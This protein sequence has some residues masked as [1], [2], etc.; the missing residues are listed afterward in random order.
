MPGYLLCSDEVGIGWTHN[1]TD[2][3]TPPPPEPAPITDDQVRAECE[4]R[5]ILFLGA[6]DLTDMKVKIS[7]GSRDAIR[8]LR[9]ENDEPGAWT[10]EDEARKAELIT[11][12]AGLEAIRAASNVLEPNPPTDYADNTYWP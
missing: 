11:A 7:N 2:F 4:R 9:K 12:D 3:V 5:M 6:R 10:A 8:L 1:G